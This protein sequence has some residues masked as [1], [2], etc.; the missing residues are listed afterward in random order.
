MSYDG[1]DP[2]DLSR[3]ED[4]FAKAE[5]RE[6]D[7]SY[8]DLPDGTY[9]VIVDRVEMK[10]SKASCNPMLSWGMK[11]IQGNYAGRWIWKHNMLMSDLNI[12]YLKEDLKRAGLVLPRL[13]DLQSSLPKLLD[14]TLEI[15]QQTK[16][17]FTNIYIQKQ[18]G[19]KTEPGPGIPAPGDSPPF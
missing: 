6:D 4:A 17:E 10:V 11:I 8:G 16:G 1:N 5:T 19:W 14:I 3:F 12:A 13:A 9:L 7:G 15:K 2:I 18:V